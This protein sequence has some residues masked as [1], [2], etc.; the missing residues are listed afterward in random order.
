MK[1]VE[2]EILFSPEAEREFGE[3]QFQQRPL[4]REWAQRYLEDLVFF[5]PEG[6]VDIRRRLDSDVFKSDNHVPFDIQGRI[7]H[8]KTSVIERVL[9]TRFRLK[10][11]A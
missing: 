6:W 3:I 1:R 10:K 5:P 4:I 2:V 7:F 11:P 9:I 8:G